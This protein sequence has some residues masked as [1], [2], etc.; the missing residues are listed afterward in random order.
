MLS[1]PSGLNILKCDLQTHRSLC[2]STLSQ[3]ASHRTSPPHLSVMLLT[4]HRNL[5][6]M[7]RR[8]MLPRWIS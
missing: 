7:C 1:L 8:T 4:S 6:C 3:Q 2:V 5:Q